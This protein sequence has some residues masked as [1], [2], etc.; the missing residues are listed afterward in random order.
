[1]N[2]SW[3]TLRAAGQSVKQLLSG[4]VARLTSRSLTLS[5]DAHTWKGTMMM[6]DPHLTSVA[7]RV[8]KLERE[9]S[10]A[11]WD[12]DPRFGAIALELQHYKKLQEEG[13]LWEPNF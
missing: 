4:C 8:R 5:E 11:E 12:D 2:Y 1:M 9:L 13:K 6:N 7:K 10:D 3:H